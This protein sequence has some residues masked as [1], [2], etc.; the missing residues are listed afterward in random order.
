MF[1]DNTLLAPTAGPILMFIHDL[2]VI[3][4]QVFTLLVIYQD[5]TP[6][7]QESEP[8][9]PRV[10]GTGASAQA[11]SER[12]GRWM[13]WWRR[14]A[15]SA[16]PTSASTQASSTNTT[17]ENTTSRT[18]ETWRTVAHNTFQH[19]SQVAESSG[20]TSGRYVRLDRITDTE[21]RDSA[22]TVIETDLESGLYTEED[23][24]GRLVLH[25]LETVR[26]YWKKTLDANTPLPYS[27]LNDQETSSSGT[28]R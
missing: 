4:L 27:L 15:S 28:A 12:T 7:T 1:T 20:S 19:I 8:T 26:Q 22:F 25:P 3:S 11:S 24:G 10:L 14:Q 16:E 17:P 21:H 9:G 6:A 18:N 5:I 13:Y 2:V 23:L